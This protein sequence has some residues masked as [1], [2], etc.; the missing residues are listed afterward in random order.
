MYSPYTILTLHRDKRLWA[1]ILLHF[2]IMFAL[3]S[4]VSGHRLASLPT[5]A[6]RSAPVDPVYR[7]VQRSKR[8]CPVKPPDGALFMAGTTPVKPTHWRY[9]LLSV[10]N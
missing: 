1:A 8:T 2:F 5:S 7:K 6:L 3:R 4:I 10:I 9:I